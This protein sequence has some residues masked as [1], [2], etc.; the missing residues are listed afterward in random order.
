MAKKQKKL[1]LS[2][3]A[4]KALEFLSE[5]ER[6]NQSELVETLV[7]DRYQSGTNQVP[8]GTNVPRMQSEGLDAAIEALSAQLTVKDAQIADY[9]ARLADATQALRDAQ[10][11]VK[12][13]Q[14][15]H[16]IDRKDDVLA[17]GS[18]EP[19]KSRWQRLKNAWRGA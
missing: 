4:L 11:S 17:V 1:M 19:E 16:A 5:R 15:L 7:L 12:A 6:C 18:P 9:S 8:A 3:D 14:T 10:E 2:D 13:A